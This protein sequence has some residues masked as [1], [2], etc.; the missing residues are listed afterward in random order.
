[1]RHETLQKIHQGHQGIQQCRLRVKTSVRWPGVSK[2]IIYRSSSTILSR[3]PEVSHSSRESL[4]QSPLPSNPWEKVAA[5]LFK[6]NKTTYFLAIVVDFFMLCG[7]TKTQ[8]HHL[9]QHNHIVLKSIFAQHGI[10]TTLVTDNRPQFISNEMSQFS[11]TYWF[12][13][14]TSSPHYHQYLMDKLI[15][16]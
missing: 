10:H 8:F 9:Y 5:D 13:H 16:L 11:S 15:M 14:V 12:H 2:D 6:L 7:N 1:M 3:M 4:I